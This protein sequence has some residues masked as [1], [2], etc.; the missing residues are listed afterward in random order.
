MEQFRVLEQGSSPYQQQVIDKDL[1]AP[2][3]GESEGD[4]YI[5]GPSATGD[6]SGHD[7]EIAWMDDSATWHFDAPVAGWL[8]W[9]IDEA[10]AYKYTGSAWEVFADIGD[11]DDVPDGIVFGRVKNTELLDNEVERLVVAW[12]IVGVDTGL[13]EIELDGDQTDKITAADSIKV[14]RSTGNDGTYT[15]ATVTYAPATKITTVAITGDLTDATVDG[16][17]T[18]V[19]SPVHVTGAEARDAYDRRGQFNPNLK[20][21]IFNMDEVT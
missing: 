6:W 7:G 10:E 4:R 20:A 1:T 3:G 5:V 2:P 9:V 12:P 17:V 8:T 16:V 15:V 13:E 19:T 21:I 11:L 14:S 18:E